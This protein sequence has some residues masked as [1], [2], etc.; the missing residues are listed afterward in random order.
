V[1]TADAPERVVVAI[2]G[3]TGAIVGIRL[4]ERLGDFGVERH[5]IVSGWGARTISHETD[6]DLDRVRALA[7]VTY[8]TNDLGAAPSSGSFLTRGM[9]IAPC[10]VK[11]LAAIATGI[12]SDLVARAADVTLK[13]RR[14]LVLVVRE[15]PLS[16]IHLENMLRLA[17]MGADIVPPMLSLYTRPASIGEM[18]DHIVTRTLD[19]LGYHSPGAKRW[20][21]DLG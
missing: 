1:K 9:V 3:A 16:E 12:S 2:T 10:S 17:R 15:S 7:D 21:G 18:V 4:L 19:Q 20:D 6:Y 14:R 13:E 8:K 5:L 11:T